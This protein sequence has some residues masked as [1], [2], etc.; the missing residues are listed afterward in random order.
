MLFR[1]HPYPLTHTH[2]H[3][4]SHPSPLT[5]THTLPSLPPHTHTHTPIPPPKHSGML[6]VDKGALR[7]PNPNPYSPPVGAPP[8]AAVVEAP[9]TEIG[10]TYTETDIL[11]PIFLFGTFACNFFYF[12]LFLI[13]TSASYIISTLRFINQYL[14]VFSSSSLPLP[15]Y[16]LNLIYHFF[17]ILLLFISF[18]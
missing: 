8:P 12:F 9:K 1:S 17:I 7:W 5:H 18:Y 2:T 15:F 10:N 6:V 4:H 13:R 16:L 3:T 14:F 11:I